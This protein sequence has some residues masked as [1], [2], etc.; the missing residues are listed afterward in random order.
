MNLRIRL[1][2][3]VFSLLFAC[4][5]N[6]KNEEIKLFPDK[7]KLKENGSINFNSLIKRMDAVKLES[8]DDCRLARITQLINHK[9]KYFI[10][11]SKSKQLLVFKEN[12]KFLNKIG[13][14]G[15]GPKE[16]IGVSN[17]IISSVDNC[18]KVYDGIRKKILFYDYNGDYIKSV[19][20]GYYVLRFGEFLNGNYWAFVAGLPD[21][22]NY[23]EGKEL[24]FVVFSPKGELIKEVFDTPY[25]GPNFFTSFSVFQNTNDSLLYT[26]VLDYSLKIFD[27]ENLSKGYNFSFNGYECSKT[28]RDKFKTDKRSRHLKKELLE[29]YI[30]GLDNVLENED[31]IYFMYPFKKQKVNVFLSKKT[32]EIIEYKG[33]PMDDTSWKTAMFPK[34]CDDNYWYT[35]IDAFRFELYKEMHTKDWECPKERI[36]SINREF[37]NLSSTDNPII[38]RY[39]LVEF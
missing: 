26:E 37:K 17:F 3:I 13:S 31:Y 5:N 19:K 18:V 14:C 11:D 8:N 34:F 28:L 24:K 4:S 30:L 10:W 35:S 1:L 2:V 9:N 12:G 39:E 36:E 21:S 7:I 25:E 15:R 27:G 29:K 20:I 16:F 32:G 6:N 38:I 33:V 22:K 23:G